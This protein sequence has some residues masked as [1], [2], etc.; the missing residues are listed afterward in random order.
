MLGGGGRTGGRV[1]L[2]PGTLYGAIKRLKQGGVI[3]ESGEK[4]D[5]EADDERRRYYRLTGFGGEVLAAEV[6]R[7]DGLVRAARREGAFPAAEPGPAGAPR[8][9]GGGGRQAGRAGAPRSPEGRLPRAEAEP[10]GD[11]MASPR[12]PRPRGHERAVGVSDRA[13]RSLL[14]A[15]PR[16]LRG[17]Y[18]EEM[19]RLFRDLCREGLEDGGGLGLA[20]LWARTLPEL[21][22]SALKERSTMLARNAVRS[23]GGVALATALVLLLPLLAGWDWGLAD[24]VFA[25]APIF[26]TGFAFVLAARKVGNTAYRAAA[27]VALAAAFMLG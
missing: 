13:Y 5:P 27:G 7:L 8:A 19:A 23:V 9:P 16:G 12:G 10:G 24:F 15:Y 22:Y 17:E 11:V 2:G 18:G 25:G 6:D 26:G 3:E 21:L 4:P 1:R 20:A 14:R